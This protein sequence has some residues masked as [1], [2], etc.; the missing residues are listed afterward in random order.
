M[1]FTALLKFSPVVL[2]AMVRSPGAAS[3]IAD[4]RE[5]RTVCVIHHARRHAQI[6]TVDRCGEAIQRIVRVIDSDG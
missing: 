1:P 3:G 4:D 6:L 2:L 5:P